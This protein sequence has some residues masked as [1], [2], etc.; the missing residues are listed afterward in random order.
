[1]HFLLGRLILHKASSSRF[2]E[3]SAM[4]RSISLASSRQMGA[5][6]AI[7]VASTKP[8]NA[9]LVLA[10]MAPGMLNLRQQDKSCSH[11]EAILRFLH[12]RANQYAMVR[13]SRSRA[14]LLTR[15]QAHPP[16]TRLPPPR[17][18]TS[19]RRDPA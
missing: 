9:I 15:Q 5:S 10:V 16:P 13:A 19:S 4:D 6:K 2:Q 11:L 14:F 17:P 12:E 8:T 18:T 7:T 1:M 3:R